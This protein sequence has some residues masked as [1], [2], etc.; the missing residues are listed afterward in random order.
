MKKTDTPHPGYVKPEMRLGSTEHI[1]KAPEVTLGAGKG[2]KG[3][4]TSPSSSLPC[5]GSTRDQTDRAMSWI[6]ALY[7]PVRLASG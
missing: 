6:L 4:E 5:C 2:T 1:R 3:E 7:G